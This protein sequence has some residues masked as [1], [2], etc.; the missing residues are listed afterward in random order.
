[1]TVDSAGNAYVIG[2]TS[3]PTITVNNGVTIDPSETGS[4]GDILL[5]KVSSQGLAQWG[6]AIGSLNNYDFGASISADNLGYIYAT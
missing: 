4:Q 1:M 3:S 2:V 6:R 5:L